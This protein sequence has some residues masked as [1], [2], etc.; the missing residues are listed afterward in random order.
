MDC[1]ALS[2]FS[3]IAKLCADIKLFAL[4]RK[5]SLSPF[6]ISFFARAD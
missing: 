5:L 1:L 3:M 4:A 6:H 2:T